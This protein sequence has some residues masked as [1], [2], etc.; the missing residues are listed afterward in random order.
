MKTEGLVT[1]D[2]GEIKAWKVKGLKE[3][4]PNEIREETGLKAA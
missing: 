1:S 3:K 4:C 2:E